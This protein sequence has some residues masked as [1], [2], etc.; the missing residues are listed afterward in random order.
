M[1][2]TCLS[3]RISEHLVEAS[4]P[5][6]PRARVHLGQQDLASDMHWASLTPFDRTAPITHIHLRDVVL[7]PPTGLI[8]QDGEIVDCVR[9]VVYPGEEPAARERIRRPAVRLA[10]SPVILGFNR[11][12]AGNY[13]HWL[14]QV[15]P[16]L[17]LYKREGCFSEA[18]TLLPVLSLPAQLESA[19]L[20]LGNNGRI[21]QLKTG[22]PVEIRDLIVSSLLRDLEKPCPA[23]LPAYKKIAEAAGKSTRSPDRMIY[24]WRVDSRARPMQNEEALVNRLLRRGIEPIITSTM[25]LAEQID[26]FS[27]AKFVMGPHGAGLANIAFCSPGAV[28]YEIFPHHYINNL[29]M[30]FAQMVGMPYFVDAFR[31]EARPDLWRHQTPW[32]VDLDLVERRLDTISECYLL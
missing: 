30:M 28:M 15:I 7:D 4:V 17:H 24:V 14:A 27:S 1:N 16:A 20:M 3:K 31:A 9:Y 26:V 18:V 5:F 13:A 6:A 23:A 22:A 2:A 12:A 21:W 25:S 32:S 10:H 8:F 11:F 19:R 29:F